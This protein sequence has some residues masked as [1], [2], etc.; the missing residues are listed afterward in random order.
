MVVHSVTTFHNP[1]I[2]HSSNNINVNIQRRPINTNA[3]LPS[4]CHFQNFKHQIT[5]IREEGT[6]PSAPKSS[7]SALCLPSPA[8]FQ[9]DVRCWPD[10]ESLTSYSTVPHHPDFWKHVLSR[11]LIKI[12]RCLKYTVYPMAV[13]ITLAYKVTQKYKMYLNSRNTI[14]NK[15]YTA[16]KRTRWH[17]A[18]GVYVVIATKT[19]HWLQICQI[20]HN[21]RAP[22][23]IPLSYIRVHAEV[24]ECSA[25]QT[26]RRRHTDRRPRQ[27]YIS[28]GT[29]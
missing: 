10:Q 8:E 6:Y 11:L 14:Q 23:T 9:P 24:Y 1:L 13:I 27:I 5:C 25:G 28:P 15:A 7:G 18:L 17:F 22:S 19:T 4:F 29:A 3:C 12:L 26:D 21:Y 16:Y 20:V 2:L